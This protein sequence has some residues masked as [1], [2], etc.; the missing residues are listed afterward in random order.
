MDTIELLT[1]RARARDRAREES[2]LLMTEN[3]H[4][5]PR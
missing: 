4:K 1:D 5:K 2:A 3:M